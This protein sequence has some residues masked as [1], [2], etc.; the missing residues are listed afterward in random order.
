M[1]NQ[2]NN[3]LL[4]FLVGLNS[5]DMKINKSGSSLFPANTTDYFL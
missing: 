1:Y 2:I 5:G 3:K 4:N